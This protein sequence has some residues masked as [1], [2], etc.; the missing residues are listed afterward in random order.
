M[1]VPVSG[2]PRCVCSHTKSKLPDRASASRQT[3]STNLPAGSRSATRTTTLPNRATSKDQTARGK[4]WAA[5]TGRFLHIA[6]N[7]MP[8]SCIAAFARCGGLLPIWAG[9]TGV[10]S[11]FHSGLFSAVNRDWGP[12][13]RPGPP[14]PRPALRPRQPSRPPP[15]R[16]GNY[17][18]DKT[19]TTLTSQ[20][21]VR[22]SVPTPH[23]NVPR[24]PFA[25]A[26]GCIPL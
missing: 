4:A 25:P 16:V 9:Q 21:Q 18:N 24:T 10:G 19:Y 22:P 13:I 2:P 5:L 8:P 23:G 15:R 3:A 1:V 17:G 26:R 12:G 14:M 20:A 11:F 6:L 7:S